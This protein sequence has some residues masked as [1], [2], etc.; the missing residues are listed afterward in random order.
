LQFDL[1]SDAI[2][3]NPVAAVLNRMFFN[4]DTSKQGFDAFNFGSSNMMS[5][6]SLE[7]AIRQQNPDFTIGP[8]K[9]VMTFDVETT[10]VFNESQV[11]SFAGRVDR[12]GQEVSEFTANFIN[13]QM[14]IASVSKSGMSTRMSSFVA[15]AES[16]GRPVFEM[17][18]QGQNFVTQAKNLFNEMLNVDHVSGHNV[19]FDINKMS[20]TLNALDAFRMD[21]EAVRL[22]GQL[23]EK[24][25]TESDFLV[26][27]AETMRGYFKRKASDLIGESGDRASR[28]VSQTLGPEMLASIG[29]GGSTA[30]ASVENITLNTNL[31]NLLETDSSPEAQKIV[32]KITGSSGSH[33]ADFDVAIQA[34]M[35]KYRQSGQ[36]GFRFD[37]ST[38]APIDN[39][40][41]DFEQYAR[42]KILKSQ[43]MVPTRD[44]ASVMHASVATRSFLTSDEGIRGATLVASGSDLGLSGAQGYLKFDKG[45]E[46]FRFHQFGSL[47]SMDVDQDVATRYIRDTY[48]QAF[49]QGSGTEST[50]RVG[51]TTARVTRNIFDEKI[52]STGINFIQTS[53]FDRINQTNM[54]MRS[55]GLATPVDL[56]DS[57][58]LMRS[59]GMTSQQFAET[60]SVESML[61]RIGNAFRGI[62][63]SNTLRPATSLSDEVNSSYMANIKR[64]GLPFTS[65]D[66]VDRVTSVGLAQVTADIGEAAGMNLTHARNAKLTSEMG[67]SYAKMT[68]SLRLGSIQSGDL[69]P[70]SRVISPFTSLFEY[71]DERRTI[72]GV[73]QVT[74]QTL[75]VKAFSQ[76]N[77]AS[78]ASG[79]TDNLLTDNI[80]NS[81][82][83]RL[84]LSFVQGSENVTPRVN[85][86][87]GANGQLNKNE[88]RSL[89][90]FMMSNLD[91]FKETLGSLDTADESLKTSINQAINMKNQF[92]S[93]TDEVRQRVTAQLADHIKDRGIVMGVVAE[94]EDQISKVNRLFKNQGIDITSNDVRLNNLAMRMV[95]ADEKTGTITMSAMSDLA[96][97]SMSGRTSQLAQ[98]ESLDALNRTL[99][100]ESQLDDAANKR[101][102]A[103][104]V[105]EAQNSSRTE[106]AIAVGSRRLQNQIATPMT[107]FYLKNKP[108]IGFAALGIAVAGVGYYMAKKNRESDLYNETMK[109]QPTGPNMGRSYSPQ[110]ESRVQS[111]RRDPLVTA[112]VV[113]NL[114]RNKIGHTQMGPNKYNH[115]YGG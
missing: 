106:E 11:R 18:E 84:T 94:G 67:L 42:N 88:S 56:A 87:F 30:P 3:T 70:A 109:A 15:E 47:D 85:L 69:V 93:E 1:A 41:S 17:G 110:Q 45:S 52:L 78:I 95:H 73:E 23:M 91:Q 16:G 40:I 53:K 12:P 49:S 5:S 51:S 82:L 89:A 75:R 83:N 2:G 77:E 19:L 38:G 8:N 107:D 92:L 112:G 10:G 32:Q 74:S 100:V 55:A 14:D 97:D 113:G 46:Q 48:Q 61:K 21:E 71:S 34:S 26:D 104:T 80:I 33:V 27:T 81:D 62:S 99:K 25:N 96:V 50:L 98:E 108:K 58:T 105:L 43:A 86:V 57:D 24:I 63:T 4:V 79:I 54:A 68:S 60:Q 103:R 64:V 66:V 115:L 28:I 22:H 31:L 101:I 76:A 65:I 9:S 114:D 111:T 13:E 102:A 90:D 6:V 20:S 37:P 36:L 39:P 7:R 35:E 59:L 29:I 72:D 44:I